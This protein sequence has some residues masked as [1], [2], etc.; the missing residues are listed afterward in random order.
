MVKNVVRAEQDGK[1][2]Y[3]V[4]ISLASKALSDKE[5]KSR[6][7]AFMRSEYK[8]VDAIEYER[9]H[10][11]VKLVY[12]LKKEKKAAPKVAPS[13]TPL[14]EPSAP[15]EPSTAVF[16]DPELEP[17]ASSVDYWVGKAKDEVDEPE[18]GKWPYVVKNE[19]DGKYLN[20]ELEWVETFD[21]ETC[22]YKSRHYANKAKDAHE[23]K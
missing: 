12:A 17:T 8:E 22:L 18:D 6:I 1:V 19:V 23:A 20:N 7:T 5:L 15:A 2:I 3:R 9:G 13:S 16:V 4:N 10:N 21:K 14:I 11:S